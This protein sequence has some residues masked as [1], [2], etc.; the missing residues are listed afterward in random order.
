MAR[1]ITKDKLTQLYD[2]LESNGIDI[3]YI[4]DSENHREINLKYI[5]GHPEDAT[6]FLDVKNR[7]TVLIPWDYQLA[8]KYSEADEIID[9]SE[10]N[11]SIMAA[12]VETVK[13][14]TD[15]SP[16]IGVLQSIAYSSVRSILDKIDDAEVIYNPLKID[17]VL[18]NL[19]STKSSVELDLLQKSFDIS[20]QLVDEMSDNIVNKW[21]KKDFREIDLA[22][23]V[24]GRM[25]EIGAEAIGFET[26]VAS[27]ARSWQIH[28]YPRADTKLGLYRKGLSLIDFGVK[29]EDF[30]SDVTLPFIFGDKDAKMKKIVETV[31]NTHD[32]AIDALGELTYLHEVA[33]KAYTTIEKE[34]FRMPHALGHGIGLTVHDAPVLCRK[35][36]HETLLKYWEAIEIKEGMVVTIE[37]GIYEQDVGGFRLENDII[38]TRNGPRIVTNSKPV[39][40]AL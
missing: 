28:T 26:L 18:E 20:N 37:P 19:R 8:E 24:E 1:F 14:I 34:G 9:V 10:Y 4:Y 32:E 13:K 3:L 30:T 39:E 36:T 12:T 7:Q 2:S 38:I 21:D 35:P 22:I 27:S 5:T 31:K 17:R 40:I 15:S 16:K 29:A 23:F 11:R 6:L 33:E 25:R